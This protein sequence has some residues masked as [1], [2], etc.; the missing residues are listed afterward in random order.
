MKK[1]ALDEILR[2]PDYEKV[3]LELRRR[4]IAAKAD[5]RVILGDCISLVFENR[6]TLSYQVQEM[7][8]VEHLYD[9]AKIQ[10]ELDAYNRLMPGMNELSATLLIEITSENEVRPTLDRLRGIDDGHALYIEIGSDRIFGAFE[11][12]HSHE[13]KLSAV[14]S[15]RFRLEPAQVAAL[16]RLEVPARL[17]VDHSRYRAQAELDPTRRSALLSDLAQPD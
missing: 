13:T 8:R 17:V 16:G 15:V 6:D 5:R 10:A 3:R 9:D 14:H 7:M 4:I 12:G 1:L 2:L 11:T